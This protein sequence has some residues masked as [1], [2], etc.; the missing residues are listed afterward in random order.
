V[1]R[2]FDH[3][4]LAT[5]T[6]NTPLGNRTLAGGERGLVHLA[7]VHMARELIEL[8]YIDDKHELGITVFDSMDAAQQ[9]VMLGAVKRY[10]FHETSDVNPSNAVFEGTA[11][12]VVAFISEQIQMEIDL[13]FDIDL[14]D[15]LA[16]DA[17]FRYL[18]HSFAKEYGYESPLE[19]DSDDWSMLMQLL[20]DRILFDE[21]Y[22]ADFG[23]LPPDQKA[24]LGDMDFG[25]NYF[26]DP[27]LP[28]PDGPKMVE[29]IRTLLRHE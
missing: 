10:L 16:G 4:G 20:H 24:A 7:F 28:E 3:K 12:A 21:D 6:W 9:L 22:L 29:I 2:D 27:P 5:M 18:A 14:E 25:T 19:Q 15:P 11:A 8:T 17:V 26:S 23:D 1:S 13:E